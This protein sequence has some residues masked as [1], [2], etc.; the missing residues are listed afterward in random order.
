MG[1]STTLSVLRGGR[2]PGVARSLDPRRAGARTILQR[3]GTA[4]GVGGLPS[5][6]R[7]VSCPWALPGAET[8]QAAPAG[9][10]SCFSVTNIHG[11]TRQ[12][13]RQRVQRFVSSTGAFDVHDLVGAVIV[14]G[15]EVGDVTVGTGG[16]REVNPERLREDACRRSCPVEF[17][18]I[19]P[20][21]P[22]LVGYV[23]AD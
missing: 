21:G 1:A 18:Q 8:Q 3:R 12:V 23:P 19:G 2:A 22:R 13:E 7:G 5:I 11:P 14:R 10:V 9:A 17:H 16:P 4:C 20:F 6:L 15:E